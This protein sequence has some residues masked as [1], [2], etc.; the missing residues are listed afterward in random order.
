MMRRGVWITVLAVVAFAAIV[1]ARLPASWVVPAPPA[2]ISCAVVDGSI[3]SGTCA[4]LTAQGSTIGDVTWN[5]HA[6]RLLTGKL[7]ANIVLTRPMGS[8]RG[9]FEAGLDKSITARNVQAQLPLDQ[10]LMSLLPRNLRTLHGNANAD[11]AFAQVVKGIVTQ[12]QGRIELHDLEDRERDIMP[13]GSYSLTFPGGN[14]DPTGQLRD[15]GGPL[16]VAGTVRLTQDEPGIDL[17]G[18]VTPRADA[19]PGLAN[20]LQYLGSPDAQGRRQFGST[21]MF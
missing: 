2:A 21:V 12:L 7:S 17:Q 19:A 15:L 9:D 11:I 16:S 13:L 8:V 20:Q 10:D 18:F 4:G 6:L 1:V 3:W 14:G 5:V